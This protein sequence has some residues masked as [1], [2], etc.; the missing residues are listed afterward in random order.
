M[1][2][3]IAIRTLPVIKN[4]KTSI[5][6]G[7]YDSLNSFQRS[8]SQ[9]NTPGALF[10]FNTFIDFEKNLLPGDGIVPLESEIMGFEQK[11]NIK[12]INGPGKSVYHTGIVRSSTVVKYL[13]KLFNHKNKSKYFKNLKSNTQIS[14]RQFET[15]MPELL[16]PVPNNQIKNPY[17]E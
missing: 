7:N 3:S 13:R 17:I 4:S 15:L 12:I 6:A 9:I 5:I 2:K 10:C 16:S 14:G 1:P 8:N 11:K